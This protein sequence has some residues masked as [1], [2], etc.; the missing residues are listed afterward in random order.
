MVE[1]IAGLLII[2]LCVG[3]VA[4]LY[5]M[6]HQTRLAFELYKIKVEQDQT[7]LL[8]KIDAALQSER[9]QR[10]WERTQEDSTPTM[11]NEELIENIRN[12]YF[13]T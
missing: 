11:I 2:G 10:S 7:D 9:E 1:L 4:A 12:N 5:C 8:L 13:G 3:P 6:L